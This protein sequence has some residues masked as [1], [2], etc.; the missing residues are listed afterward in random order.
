[1]TSIAVP[2]IAAFAWGQAFGSPTTVATPAPSGFAGSFDSLY[3]DFGTVPHGSQQVHR[4]TFT[5]GSDKEVQ[6]LGVRSSC[7]CASPRAVNDTA[8]PGEKI[9]IEVMYDATKFLNE[10]SMTITVD[11]QSDHWEQVQIKV[12]G[13]SRQDVILEPGKVDLG[14]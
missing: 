13:F 4:F 3:K 2:L 8:K 12:R 11:M 14:V 9:V 10:R 7:H 1:M 6:V 5:N